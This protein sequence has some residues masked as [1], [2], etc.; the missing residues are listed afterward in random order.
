MGKRIVAAFDFDGTLTTKDTLWEFIKFSKGKWRLYA[1]MLACS[2]IL[3]A[4]LLHLYPNDKAKQVVFCH[5]FKGMA[6]DRFRL[7][8][9]AFASRVNDIVNLP[10][11]E[12]LEAHYRSGATV[13][14]VSASISEWVEPWCK[15]HHVSHVLCTQIEVSEHGILTGR[16]LSKNCYGKEKV[17]RLLD[18]EPHRETYHLIAYGDSGGDTELLRFADEGHIIRHIFTS[19]QLPQKP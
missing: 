6:Y 10:M 11:L 3:V 19:I 15:A 1:G 4:Y 17:R 2:P 18:V 9:E 8:G 7:L 13:C 16:F 14:V 12:K 5:F